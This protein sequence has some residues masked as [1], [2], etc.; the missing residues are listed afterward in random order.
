VYYLGYDIPPSTGELKLSSETYIEKAIN[1]FPEDLIL[2]L[3]LPTY[4]TGDIKPDGGELPQLKKGRLSRKYGKVFNSSLEPLQF[5]DFD[6]MELTPPDA[7]AKA[8]QTMLTDTIRKMKQSGTG[9]ERYAHLEALV[10][11]L[12]GAQDYTEFYAKH[13]LFPHHQFSLRM[14]QKVVGTLIYIATKGRFDVQVHASMLSQFSSM[15]KIQ[16]FFQALQVLRYAYSTR[17]SHY[18]F[19][20]H[21]TALKKKANG[22]IKEP[23]TLDVYTDASQLPQASQGGYYITS[24][25]RYM[26]SKSFRTQHYDGCSYYA[27]MLALR[28]GIEAVVTVKEHLRDFGYKKVLIDVHCDNFPLVQLVRKGFSSKKDMDKILLNCYYMLRDNLK[29]DVFDIAHVSGAANPADLFRLYSNGQTYGTSGHCIHVYTN[30]ERISPETGIVHRLSAGDN[31]KMIPHIIGSCMCDT[32]CLPA[33]PDVR[34][35]VR[36]RQAHI[37][38]RRRS[39]DVRAYIQK[40]EGM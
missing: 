32:F 20:R 16:H 11:K 26:T 4:R 33:P 6:I 28:T 35:N 39:R 38:L 3:K 14:Y 9:K 29:D 12:H 13:P 1:D 7:D 24:K 36:K 19:I 40:K 2:Y 17:S 22:K 31:Y 25:H 15:P 23:I 27:E 34:D 30:F 37:S 18:Q 5:E 21:D 10:L 8:F